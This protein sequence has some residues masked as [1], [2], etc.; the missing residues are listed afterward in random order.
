MSDVEARR[1][2]GASVR[3][4]AFCFTANCGELCE[5]IQNLVGFLDTPN[6]AQPRPR[7]D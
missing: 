4:K 5:Q 1:D 2:E 3:K 6:F 7:S